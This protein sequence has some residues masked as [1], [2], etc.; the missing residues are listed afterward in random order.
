MKATQLAN[1]VLLVR[2]GRRI[3][4]KY[5]RNT[6]VNST[7][8]SLRSQRRHDADASDK[9]TLEPCDSVRLVLLLASANG[10]FTGNGGADGG[11][12][13]SHGRHAAL[14]EP[15]SHRWHRC[16]WG[17]S[18]FREIKA[19]PSNPGDSAHCGPNG[20]LRDA[21]QTTGHPRE[22][23]RLGLGMVFVGIYR[24]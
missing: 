11:H 7:I 6:S 18:S 20:P 16:N 23:A 10:N 14:H 19:F 8:N 3:W 22:H 21:E 13:T 4:S 1:D 24:K 9:S 5:A 17:N 15:H 2:S 12:A